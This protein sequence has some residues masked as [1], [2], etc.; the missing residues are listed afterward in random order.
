MY[1]FHP[2][3]AGYPQLLSIKFKLEMMRFGKEMVYF[4]LAPN[5]PNSILGFALS[6]GVDSSSTSGDD[7]ETLPH[8][9]QIP[10]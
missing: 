9:A 1:K 5:L 7:P 6:S 10:T 3:N 4:L 2:G 8:A